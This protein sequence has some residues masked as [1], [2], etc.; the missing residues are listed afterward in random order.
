[1]YKLILQFKENFRKK[2][3]ITLIL[4]RKANDKFITNSKPKRFF[5]IT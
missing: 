4:I 3:K 1:M 2:K 5:E